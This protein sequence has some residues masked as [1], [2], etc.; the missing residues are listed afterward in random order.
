M[1][2]DR[3]DNVI[4]SELC[5]CP[6][7]TME[8]D[9]LADLNMILNRGLVTIAG[10]FMSVDNRGSEVW[11]SASSLLNHHQFVNVLCSHKTAAFHS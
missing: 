5:L 7:P 6:H 11:L 1:N 4:F 3:M 9:I 8:G 2:I 10:H